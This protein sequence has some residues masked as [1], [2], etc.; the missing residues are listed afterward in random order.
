[1]SQ[2]A[3]A[4]LE[5]PS[6]QAPTGHRA[7]GVV[8]V[9]RWATG[10]ADSHEPPE[11]FRALATR[12]DPLYHAILLG[13]CACVL[14]AAFFL[15]VRDG[16][17]VVLP[18][19]HIPLPELCTARLL[20][21]FGC[22]GCGLTRSFISLA[23]GDIATA[24]SYNPAGLWLFAI[25]AL[26]IPFRSYQLWRLRRGQAEI[27]LRGAAQPALLIFAI[28]VLSQWTLRLAGVSF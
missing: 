28:A 12:P 3:V 10:L 4:G 19:L 18:L 27:E 25:M 7:T 20:T 23:H 9:G 14:L 16:S 6:P 15:S 26:Q 24:W 11:A 22:P 5:I 21:G 8:G 1:M 17:Q 13:L 2:P